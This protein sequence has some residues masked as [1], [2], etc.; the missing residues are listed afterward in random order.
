MRELTQEENEK[1]IEVIKILKSATGNE[2]SWILSLQEFPVK[3]PKIEE[4]KTYIYADP[5]CL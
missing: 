1:I 2:N 4:I 5:K 3:I